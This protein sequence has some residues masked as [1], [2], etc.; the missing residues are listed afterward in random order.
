MGGMQFNRSGN[1]I[2]SVPAIGPGRDK[3]IN[4]MAQEMLKYTPSYQSLKPQPRD[5]LG[6]LMQDTII[7]AI[8][9]KK[10]PAEMEAIRQ[11]VLAAQKAQ[12][13]S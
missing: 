13:Q 4:A 7:T 3:I 12:E 10:S 6:L 5:N 8:E 2:T 9:G 11:K 1:R